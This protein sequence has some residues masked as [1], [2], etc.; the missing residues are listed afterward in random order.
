M[1]CERAHDLIHTELDGEL[2]DDQLGTLNEHVD[3]C[4]PCRLLRSQF[5]AMQT[6]FEWL[7]DQSQAPLQETPPKPAIIPL[8]WVRRAAGFAAAAAAAVALYLALPFGGPPQDNQFASLTSNEPKLKFELTGE[9]FD[10]YLAVERHTEE[11]H[12]HIVWLYKNQ[13]YSKDSS[14]LERPKTPVHS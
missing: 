13:G 8:P 12:V 6:S 10:K 11:P 5:L 4:E 9:S 1:N 14:S 2:A 3:T 7:T